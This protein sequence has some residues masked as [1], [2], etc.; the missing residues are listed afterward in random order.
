MVIGGTTFE[1]LNPLIKFL[2]KNPILLES[3]IP[4]LTS[5]TSIRPIFL[6]SIMVVASSEVLVVSFEI[7]V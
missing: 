3:H 4:V 5:M 7:V 6:F 1:F 2:A